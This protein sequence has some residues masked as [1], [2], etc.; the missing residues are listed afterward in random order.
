[1]PRTKQPKPTFTFNGYHMS[2]YSPAR[3][4]RQNVFVES[5]DIISADAVRVN[6]D[7]GVM[8]LERGH[9]SFFRL[10][11]GRPR[12]QRPGAA[13]HS[14]SIRRHLCGVNATKP[15]EGGTP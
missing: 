9:S 7:G 15:F 1:M 4:R 6:H 3:R 2:W 11:A 10:Y 12:L 8:I 13:L 14:R 5:Y